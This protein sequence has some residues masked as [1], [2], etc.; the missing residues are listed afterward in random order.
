MVSVGFCFG[1]YLS[2]VPIIVGDFYGHVNFGIYF[3]YMQLGSTGATFIIPNIAEV[4]KQSMVQLSVS[5]PQMAFLLMPVLSYRGTTTLFLSSLRS[6]WV[7][8]VWASSSNDPH[9][10]ADGEQ[11]SGFPAALPSLY[12]G[13]GGRRYFIPV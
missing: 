2:V 6:V 9:Q 12:S 11:P 1:T 8:L 5:A 7:F 13:P 3:G 10:S 4:V